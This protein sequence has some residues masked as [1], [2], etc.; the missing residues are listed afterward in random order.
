MD[1]SP[2]ELLHPATEP[3]LAAELLTLQVA[4]YR[5]EAALIGSD[6]ATLVA[7]GP[8][9]LGCRDGEG[10]LGA[11]AITETTEMIGI[12]PSSSPPGGTT[13]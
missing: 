10:L 1:L 13:S 8:S 7:A 5:V 11:G 3:R 9:R 4:A 6:P 2:V 12:G